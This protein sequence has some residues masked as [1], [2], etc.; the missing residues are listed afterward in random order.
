MRGSTRE[1]FDKLVS[2]IK[3]KNGGRLHD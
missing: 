3:R 1:L 2:I